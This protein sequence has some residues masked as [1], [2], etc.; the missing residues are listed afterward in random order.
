MNKKRFYIY[1]FIFSLT[2]YGW[3]GW[4]VVKGPTDGDGFTPCLFKTVT[5]LPCP[6]CGTTRALL[7][8]LRGDVWDSIM[9]NP[10]GIIA[11]L[12]LLVIPLWIVFD[13]VRKSDSF[14]RSYIAAERLMKRNL[15]VSIPLIALVVSNWIWNIAKGL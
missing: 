12:A 13:M 6:S 10:L 15:A 1:L 9:M 3:L 7:M 14:Y 11:L 2:A 8:L 4:N 5:H